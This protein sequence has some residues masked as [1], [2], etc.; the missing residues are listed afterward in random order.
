MKI[1][2][3]KF[4]SLKK[5]TRNKHSSAERSWFAKKMISGD[6]TDEQYSVYLKQQ[7]L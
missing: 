4:M 1:L 3:L 7:Y 6:I 5:M 2:L